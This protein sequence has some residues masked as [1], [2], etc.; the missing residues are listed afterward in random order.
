[1]NLMTHGTVWFFCDQDVQERELV[2]SFDFHREGDVGVLC[3]E[4]ILE[5]IEFFFFMLSN[6]KCVI[7]ITEPCFQFQLTFLDGAEFGIFHKDVCNNWGD[8]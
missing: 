5:F 8:W 2:V 7:H 3:V 1:M 4:E 6:N